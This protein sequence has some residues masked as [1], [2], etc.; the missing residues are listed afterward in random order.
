MLKL[1][2]NCLVAQAVLVSESVK[3]IQGNSV[4]QREQNTNAM[5][6]C[7]KESNTFEQDNDSEDC[8]IG[9]LDESMCQ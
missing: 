5:K 1:L 3:N 7:A 6:T 4:F 9:E 8:D 2:L